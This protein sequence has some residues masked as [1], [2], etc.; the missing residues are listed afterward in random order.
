MAARRWGSMGGGVF[1][2]ALTMPNGS[3]CDGLKWA[4]T[5]KKPSAARY[6]AHQRW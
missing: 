1:N 5:A 6:T 2:V 4:A 3:L